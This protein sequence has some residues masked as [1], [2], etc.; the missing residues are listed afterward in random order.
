LILTFVAIARTI[1]FKPV[2]IFYGCSESWLNI[3]FNDG[4]KDFEKSI[5]VDF[6]SVKKIKG[7]KFIHH[8]IKSNITTFQRPITKKCKQQNNLIIT[9]LN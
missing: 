8:Q 6:S 4:A 2:I 5:T 3:T 1:K 9:K 7:Y